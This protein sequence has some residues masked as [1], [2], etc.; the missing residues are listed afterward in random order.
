MLCATASTRCSRPPRPVACLLLCGGAEVPRGEESGSEAACGSATSNSPRARPA[1]PPWRISGPGGCACRAEQVRDPQRGDACGSKK[2]GLLAESSVFARLV[3]VVRVELELSCLSSELEEALHARD[4]L[5]GVSPLRESVRFIEQAGHD[6]RLGG[7]DSGL[8]V[9][10][11][12]RGERCDAAGKRVD[13]WAQLVLLERAVDVAPLLREVCVDVIGAEDDFEC[14]RSTYEV[15]ESLGASAAGDDPHANLRLR[16][17][18]LTACG[19]AHV[20]RERELAAATAGASL[21]DRDR[22]LRHR[23]ESV[24]HCVEERELGRWWLRLSGQ[25]EDQVHVGV[26]DEELGVRAVDHDDPDVRIGLDFAAKPVQL[27]DQRPI[28][29]IDR[30]VVNRRTGDTPVDLNSKSAMALDPAHLTCLR[31][32]PGPITVGSSETRCAAR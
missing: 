8:R 22:C 4:R 26:R 10:D 2:A 24:R 31:F 11:R 16:K 21:D 32:E 23:S 29:E 12:V 27:D 9:R 15:R 28:E 1:A 30:R 13:E 6:V 17:H 7:G 14:A 18:R 25:S 5:L 19:E 3:W 20:H